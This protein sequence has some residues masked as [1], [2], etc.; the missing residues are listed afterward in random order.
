VEQVSRALRK[1][2][3]A[4]DAADARSSPTAGASDGDGAREPPDKTSTNATVATPTALAIA[5]SFFMHEH[6]A[7]HV[8]TVRTEDSVAGS[9][10]K[11]I[12]CIQENRVGTCVRDRAVTSQG[13]PYAR[14]RR[15]IDT[16]NAHLAWVAATEVEFIDLQDA[17][18]LVLLVVGDRRQASA[19]TRWLGRLC[20][21][22]PGVTL[23]R[24]QLAADA[25]AGLPDPAAAHALA[26][27]CKELGLSRA[28]AATRRA[29]LDV[30]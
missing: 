22:A 5:A 14:L 11:L 19:S 23:A 12:P 18:E 13:R 28:A 3:A 21:E 26:S 7:A 17:L 16:G 9:I 24:A 8:V 25:L 6:Y 15:A 2:V 29:F 30:S 20:L 4:K 1:E 10:P 27:L